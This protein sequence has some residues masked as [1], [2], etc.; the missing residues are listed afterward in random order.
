MTPNLTSVCRLLHLNY[1]IYQAELRGGKVKNKSSPN[2]KAERVNPLPCEQRTLAFGIY[3]S[4]DK[5]PVSQ[6][7]TLMELADELEASL[8]AFKK[9]RRSLWPL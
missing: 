4:S 7:K 3:N 2:K 6:P 8:R 1:L 9:L 5:S